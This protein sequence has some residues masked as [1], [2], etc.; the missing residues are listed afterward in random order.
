[1]TVF[2]VQV[3]GSLD[4]GSNSRR[5]C[6]RIIDFVAV[7]DRGSESLR[8]TFWISSSHLPRS[9]VQKFF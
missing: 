8:G 4:G 6:A 3:A 7:R 5:Q 1:L 9:R 2:S